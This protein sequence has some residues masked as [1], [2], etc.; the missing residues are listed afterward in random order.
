MSQI[1]GRVVTTVAATAVRLTLGDENV[2]MTLKN[3]DAANAL[4]FRYESLALT[5]TLVGASAAA[6]QA[7]GGAPLL[8]G[9]AVIIPA[10]TPWIDVACITA[11]TA[12]LELVPAALV[13]STSVTATIGAITIGDG[14]NAAQGTTTDVPLAGETA[15]SA[16]AR[17]GVSLWK[18]NVNKL[19]EIKALMATSAKQ[20]ADGHAVT[21]DNL[22]SNEVY[23]R[24][25]GT[26]GSADAAVLT[27]QG[28]GSG[29]AVT[30]TESSPITGFAT[31]SGGNLAAAA[32]DLNELTAA[33]VAKAPVKIVKALAG[34]PVPLALASSETFVTAFYLEAART[35]G[36]NTGDIFIGLI[37]DLVSG[38]INYFKLTPGEPFQYVCRPGTKV[39]LALWG[40]D[41]ETGT[42]GVIGVHEPV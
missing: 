2:P 16:T 5:A 11:Q 22:I 40:I 10:N 32:A 39:K 9:E 8:A 1:I 42:D 13:D 4:F 20:L 29:T 30:V 35:G 27:I 28:I 38:S 12:T 26:A 6:V 3:T 19:I 25:S 31:E 17:T 23:V 34:S 37:A 14:G 36:V 24:G 15:E 21:I 41:G 18:R 7:T 33:P